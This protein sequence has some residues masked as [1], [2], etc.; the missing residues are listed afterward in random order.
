MKKVFLTGKVTNGIAISESEYH[1][2]VTTFCRYEHKLVKAGYEVINPLCHTA[3]HNIIKQAQKGMLEYMMK[4]EAIFIIP[5]S[6]DD[7]WV[8][9]HYHIANELGYIYVSEEMLQDEI[10]TNNKKKVKAYEI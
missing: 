2:A 7:K 8:Q 5:N 9:L 10:Q 6:F 3:P 4:A 1:E